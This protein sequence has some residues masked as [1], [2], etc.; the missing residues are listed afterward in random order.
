MPRKKGS[1]DVLS[2]EEAELDGRAH[3]D[4]VL[5]DASDDED[6]TRP[7]SSHAEALKWRPRLSRAEAKARAKEMR[8]LCER[9]ARQREAKRES[10]AAAE[11]EARP[12]ND[13][14][15]AAVSVADGHL[16]MAA[17]LPTGTER[18]YKP[19]A[20][21]QRVLWQEDGALDGVASSDHVAAPQPSDVV[22]WLLHPEGNACET[23]LCRQWVRLGQCRFG[24]GCRH[25]H[26]TTLAGTHGLV[27]GR[28][29]AMPP[30]EPMA[31]PS[32]LTTE[33]LRRVAFIVFTPPSSHQTVDG[34][35]R[36]SAQLAY[37]YEDPS[38]AVRYEARGRRGPLVA[39]SADDVPP[40]TAE[41]VQRQSCDM[42]MHASAAA[43]A[44]ALPS[45]LPAELWAQV[46]CCD[47]LDVRSLAA[48][49]CSCSEL[50]R[51]VSQ[52]EPWSRAQA[53]TFGA[54]QEGL[55]QL[56][57]F[58]RISPAPLPGVA[59]FMRLGPRE[60]CLASTA[61]LD[62]W[63]RAAGRSPRALP[64]PAMT[65]VRVRVR[66]RLRGRVRG[67]GRGGRARARARE[68]ALG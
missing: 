16:T 55:T 66:V 57:G 60:R 2:R 46:L 65:A 21:L 41:A 63:R 14:A 50:A 17:G 33:Q 54:E 26:S 30:I 56:T 31:D 61:A 52:P 35:G 6:A 15:E 11:S 40:D 20:V 19:A 10:S 3:A 34:G 64:L 24:S 27:C 49:A 45:A 25:A 8:E 1:K 22:V 7:T 9:R 68:R 4:G 36:A 59:G 58:L 42:R 5:N 43:P 32:H 39:V 62:N 51:H 47:R 48:L 12:L 67:R 29:A 23:R 53:R 13:L 28:G 44:L 37:D 38:A 18:Q